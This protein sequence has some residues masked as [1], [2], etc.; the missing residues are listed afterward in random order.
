[1]TETQR[2]LLAELLRRFDE[3]E[4]ALER[5]EERI[6]QE[7]QRAREQPVREAIV[8][9]DG[10]PGIGEANAEARHHGGPARCLSDFP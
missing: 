8:V 2:W 7:I 6:D 3:A 9:L 1:L 5:V 10:I 4:A